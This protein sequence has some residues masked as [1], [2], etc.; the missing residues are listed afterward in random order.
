MTVELNIFNLQRQ[1]AIFDECDSVSWLNVYTCDDSCADGLIDNDVCDEINF[2]DEINSL[3]PDSSDPS[4]FAHPLDPALELKPL[5]DF[6][7]YVFLGP[8]KT[9][10]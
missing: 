4:S 10:L 8:N 5:P 7:M 1:P 3:S 9:F 6:L 2:C